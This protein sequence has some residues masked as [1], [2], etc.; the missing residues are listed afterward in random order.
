MKLKKHSA[1]SDDW[2]VN[3]ETAEF[4]SPSK[5]SGPNQMVVFSDQK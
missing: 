1:L 4:L 3:L 2:H 5:D